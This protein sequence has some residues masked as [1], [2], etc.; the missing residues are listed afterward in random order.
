MPGVT[1]LVPLLLHSA[2]RFG[3]Y[4]GGTREC[5]KKLDVQRARSTLAGTDRLVRQQEIEETIEPRG[6]HSPKI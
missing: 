1:F 3:K 5:K 6:N 2:W 4:F